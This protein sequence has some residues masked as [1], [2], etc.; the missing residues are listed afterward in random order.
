MTNAQG[1]NALGSRILKP[2]LSGDDVRSLQYLLN[3]ATPPANPQLVQNGQF[4]SATTQA[5]NAWK[6]A[7]NISN[8]GEA[9]P[10]TL[11]TLARQIPRILRQGLSGDDV[12]RLQYLL[13]NATPSANPKLAES[14]QFDAATTRALSAWKTA[15]KLTSPN[16]A[17]PTTL[18]ALEQQVRN[19]PPATGTTRILRQGLSGDD[20]KRLQYLL[21]RAV[22]PATPR[23]T[24]D[25]K[26][27][28]TT[29]QAL[30]RWKAAY[31][32]TGPGEAGPTTLVALE[33]N[34]R[35]RPASRPLSAAQLKAIMPSARTSDI[36]TY[37]SPLNQ[38]MQEFGITTPNRQ[39][40][41]IAQLAHESGAFRYKQEIAS[42]AAYEGRRDL[43]NVY[44]GDGRRYKG[45]G[46]IQITGR[47]NYREVGRALGVNLEANPLK[48]LDPV[49][50][51]RSA[52][53]F[54]KSRGLNPLADI[55]KFREITRRING[56]YNGY[57]DRVSYYNRAKA[58]IV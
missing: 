18:A 20:V 27:G 33:Q 45:R 13:N 17:G 53:Y 57:S 29:T 58:V 40:A 10:T 47:S 24:E 51:A 32:L 21:N 11:A 46:L 5:L 22:P 31:G 49:I 8:P 12:R 26:F 2:G 56:G 6:T 41:F 35:N 50:S 42:G 54:W 16:E 55:G 23:L 14:G 30:N 15:N 44:A 43:G 7:N 3:H 34:V 37:L 39:R 1:T 4:D 52:A 9:G 25:G 19:K 36:N 38:A 28:P 48:L